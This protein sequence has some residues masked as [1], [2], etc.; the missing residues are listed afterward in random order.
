MILARLIK[1]QKA[2]IRARMDILNNI[3]E[4]LKLA[5]EADAQGHSAAAFEFFQR[6]I[7][8]D[9]GNDFAIYRAVITL[10]ELGR[11]SDAEH[12]LNKIRWNAAPKPYL[13]ESVLG[14][15]RLAQFRV[16]EAEQHFRNAWKLEPNSTVPAVYLGNCLLKQEKFDEANDILIEALNVQD[17]LDEVYLNLGC[18]KRATGDYHAA[19]NYFLKALEITP[20]YPNAIRGL[21]DVELWL[22]FIEKSGNSSEI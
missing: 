17:D 13:I 5:K 21:A 9:P 4:C 8:L 18:I 15:L 14:R 20:D 3:E 10:L 22:S 1:R 12:F 19:R 7:A 6:V 2:T 11:I 16:G